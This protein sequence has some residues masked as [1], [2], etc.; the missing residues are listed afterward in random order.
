M[1]NSILS[2]MPVG[3]LIRDKY[4][5]F[6]PYYQRGYR[7]RKEQVE[8]L[9]D[10][11][12]NFVRDKENAEKYYSLQPLVV[13]NNKSQSKKCDK[14]THQ[15]KCNENNE[16]QKCYSVIDGQQRLTT[17]YLLAK[18]LFK[19]S[20]FTIFYESRPEIE[21]YLENISIDSQEKNIEQH[22]LHQAYVVIHEWFGRVFGDNLESQKAKR[23]ENAFRALEED[24]EYRL[25]FIWYDITEQNNGNED[26]IELFNRLNKGHLSLTSAELIKAEFCGEIRIKYKDNKQLA[27]EEERRFFR[28]WNEIENQ[29]QDD[30]FWYFICNESASGKKY[31]TRIEYL[32]DLLINQQAAPQNIS[33]DDSYKTF[34]QYEIYKKSKGESFDERKEIWEFFQTL[35]GWYYDRNFFHLIGFLIQAEV[36]LTEIKKE[37]ENQKTR[38]NM[39]NALRQLI[40][41]KLDFSLDNLD[42]KNSSHKHKIRNILLLFNVEYLLQNKNS[43]QRFQFD[44]YQSYEW[45]LEHI[46]SQTS[47]P[48]DSSRKNWAEKVLCYMLKMPLLESEENQEKKQSKE[49]KRKYFIL[50]FQEAIDAKKCAEQKNAES[51]E[52]SLIEKLF[53]YFMKDQNTGVEF[54]KLYKD[55]RGAEIFQ[56]PPNIPKDDLTN[57]TLLDSG[58]NRGYGNAPFAVKRQYIIEKEKAGLF[59]PPCTRDVFLKTFSTDVRN[60]FFWDPQTDGLQHLNAIKK[61]LAKK[62]YLDN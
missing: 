7:W 8:K 5:F 46:C 17:I 40:K 43:N 20:I 2:P 58:T 48:G 28:E 12:Y 47:L 44:V 61:L 10:D 39:V 33:V 53:N 3:K 1:T 19:K 21:S 50:K 18:Y 45:D 57:L 54:E 52:M 6:I 51:E 62:L 24:D 36:S 26:E 59:I 22:F 34:H 41:K 23:F 30:A 9:L 29:F 13:V 42:F 49:E 56:E 14:C 16:S 32:F 31:E 38:Q 35:L 37:I 25:Q 60:M 4:N 11:I 27:L 55:V 15:A